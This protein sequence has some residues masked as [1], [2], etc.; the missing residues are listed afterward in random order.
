MVVDK[1]RAR[2]NTI[3]RSSCFQ[4]EA[5]S[6]NFDEFMVHHQI[7]DEKRYLRRMVEYLNNIT[8]QLVDG[9]HTESNNVR[10]LRDALLGKKWETTSLK[11]ITTA[12]YNFEQLVMTLNE[13][14]Q[15][16]LQAQK[17]CKSS[18]TY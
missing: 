16:E 13:S 12:Q 2:Y 14:I 18:K 5:D 10:Y 6:L 9:F 4:S 3:D 1:L 17:A 8:P 7:Q 11:N 15:L